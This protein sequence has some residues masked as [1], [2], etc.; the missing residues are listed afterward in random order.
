MTDIKKLFKEH[1]P[2][3]HIST[4]DETDYKQ[5]YKQQK[6]RA[7]EYQY[8]YHNLKALIM[9]TQRLINEDVTNPEDIIENLFD[10]IDKMESR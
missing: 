3:F 5:L 1:K 2:K 9:D 10:E 4:D 7:D 8:K 6:Q